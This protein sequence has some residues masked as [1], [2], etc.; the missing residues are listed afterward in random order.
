MATVT[1]TEKAVEE[2]TESPTAPTG[3]TDPS[4]DEP[5]STNPTE[6]TTSTVTES[7]TQSKNESGN[8]A[9]G[10][11]D[12]LWVLAVLAFISLAAVVCVN[13]YAKKKKDE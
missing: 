3:N 11:L 13:L 9:T 8:F 5:T 12:N 4:A 10:V 7:D 1:V 2:P 6:P